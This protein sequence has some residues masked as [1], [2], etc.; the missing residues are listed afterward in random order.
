M[1]RKVLASDP[2][3]AMTLNYLGYMLA[4]RGIKLD[5]ALGLIKKAVELDPANGAYLD[6]L[7]WAYFKLGK[8]ES[9]GR[10][11]DQGLAAHRHR[12]HGAGPPG[13][14]LSEDRTPE[15]GGRPLG[16]R[17]WPSGTRRS[18]PEV[19]TDD[20][21][22]VQKKLESAKMRLAQ[23]TVGEAVKASFKV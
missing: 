21:A 1:F 20:F 6:S 15:A 8:Y 16:A 23:G 13:R 4:D 5:E 18:L 2:Q 11:P 3:N 12:P 10:E 9:G 17:R 14:P 22:R 19:D 7:G